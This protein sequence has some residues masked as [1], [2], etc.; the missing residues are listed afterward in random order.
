MKSKKLLTLIFSVTALLITSLIVSIAVMASELPTVDKLFK[1][2][3]VTFVRQVTDGKT[4]EMGLLLTADKAGASAEFKLD[5]SETLHINLKTLNGSVPK[6]HIELTDAL[7]QTFSINSVYKSAYDNI[8]VELDGQKAGI[9]QFSDKWD[10]KTGYTAAYNTKLETYTQFWRTYSKENRNDLENTLTAD[11]DC[12]HLEFNPQTMQVGIKRFAADSY[13]LIW[14]LSKESN[15]GHN[16]GTSLNYFGDYTFKIVFDEVVDN[17]GQILIYSINDYDLSRD[18]LAAGDKQSSV[19]IKLTSNAQLGKQYVFPEAVVKSIHS[20]EVKSAVATVGG[21]EMQSYTPTSGN[22]FTVTYKC[23]DI[24][25]D[26]EIPIVATVVSDLDNAEIPVNVGVNQRVELAS[27]VLSTNLSYFNALVNAS[28]TVKDGENNNVALENGTFVAAKAGQYTVTYTAL[29]GSFTK[30][31]T[32]NASNDAVGINYQQFAEVYRIGHT[33]T[34]N[35]PAVLKNGASVETVTTVKFPSGKTVASGNVV[36]DEAGDYTVIHTYNTGVEETFTQKIHVE[37]ASADLFAGDAKVDSSYGVVDGNNDFSGV[38]L[39]FDGNRTVEYQKIIDLSDNRFDPETNTGDL[40]IELVAQPMSIGTADLEKIELFFTDVNDPN[41]VLSISLAYFPA[42]RTV[43]KIHAKGTG[44]VYSARRVNGEITTVLDAGFNSRHSFIQTVRHDGS[45]I[46]GEFENYTLKLYYDYEENALYGTPEWNANSYLILDFD[47][48]SMFPTNPW[49]GFSNG[50]VKMSVKVSGVASTADIFVLNVDGQTFDGEYFTDTKAPLIQSEIIG[51]APLAAVDTPYPLIPFDAFDLQSGISDMWWEVTDKSGVKQTLTNNTFTPKKQGKYNVTMFAKDF[52]GNVSSQTV[53]VNA[54]PYVAGVVLN[55]NGTVPQNVIYGQFVELPEYSVDSGAGLTNVTITVT[56]DGVNIPVDDFKFFV[57][58]EGTYIVTYKAEDYI[59]NTNYKSFFVNATLGA[60]PSIDEST[61]SLPVAFI[62]GEKYIFDNYKASFY[63]GAGATEELIGAKITVTD[64]LGTR[65]LDGREYTPVVSDSGNTVDSITVK[66][67]FEKDGGIPL[68]IERVVPAVNPIATQGYMADY[69]LM[70]NGTA[71][72]YADGLVF[73]ASGTGDMTV[74]YIR[75]LSTKNLSL[76]FVTSGIVEEQLTDEAIEE[77]KNALVG[78]GKPYATAEEL[79]AALELKDESGEYIGVEYN[80]QKHYKIRRFYLRESKVDFRNFGSISITL[81]DAL[82][83]SEQVTVTYVRNG[84]QFISY[85]CGK[86][87]NTGAN[88]NNEFFFRYSAETNTVSDANN[89]K[90]GA[91]TVNDAG[92]A[93][94]GFTSGNVYVSIKV[95]NIIGD[96]SM[97]FKQINNH[98]FND[99]SS[100]NITPV[101][102]LN[103]TVDGRYQIGSTALIPTADAYDVLNAISVPKV[104]ITAPDGTV[105]LENAPT[106]IEY[107][108]TLGQYGTY[109]VVYVVNDGAGNIITT[110]KSIWVS[111]DRAPTLTFSGSI[112]KT[113]KVGDTISLPS[114]T[115][116]DNDLSGVK[117]EITFRKPNGQFDNVKGNSVKFDKAGRY[118]INYFVIDA[119][120]NTTVYSYSV[121]VTD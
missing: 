98:A 9:Y 25:R 41:N 75:A 77:L 87:A 70:E 24:T 16:I 80:G 78:E 8:Y 120:R 60:K 31:F 39:T 12:L 63:A 67:V 66:I 55:I 104:T 19:A 96:C 64:A 93:F 105:L 33:L 45:S 86:T 71:T 79:D 114:Y 35:V 47:D 115:V 65:T 52:F 57:E 48:S 15:D 14:D 113:A 116:H 49:S 73:K 110:T 4:D 121:V 91:L 76:K 53:S 103:G 43:T 20:D 2:D 61:I 119:D 36:L 26:V 90:L 85:V 13:M 81:R 118:T 108:L 102:W 29:D 32:V 101:L 89:N 17:D 21:T 84:S 30:Q 68:E 28:V 107:K 69:F 62:H 111:D 100:D 51:S 95:E 10:M 72:A 82:N 109:M 106:D 34:V 92:K 54:I 58:H 5:L 56:K 11:A 38:K 7:G 18:R 40:L 94:S 22:K 3:G 44:Q 46:S 117:V 37:E 27:S 99:N 59:G 1:G 42:S 50:Q 23:D 83:P 74:E 88:L 97:M 6:F 112:S